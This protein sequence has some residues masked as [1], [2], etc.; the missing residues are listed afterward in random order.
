MHTT[1]VSISGITSSETIRGKL[2]TE[3]VVRLAQAVIQHPRAE[4]LFQGLDGFYAW[5]DRA[6][7]HYLDEIDRLGPTKARQQVSRIVND[8]ALIG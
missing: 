2:R 6:Q 8:V 3:A 5:I 1:T 4:R 7:Q